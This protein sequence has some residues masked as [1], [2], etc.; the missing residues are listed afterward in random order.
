MK[1]AGVGIERIVHRR[2]RVTVRS[3]RIR[4]IIT[5]EGMGR[6]R[7]LMISE[8]TGIGR[9]KEI[10]MMRIGGMKKTGSMRFTIPIRGQ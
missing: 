10:G 5:R 4:G 8:G 9:I 6:G 3:R 7:D 1:G 2:G